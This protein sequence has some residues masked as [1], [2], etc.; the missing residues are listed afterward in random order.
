[1]K[2]ISLI[3]NSVL[4]ICVGMCVCCKSHQHAD[5][6]TKFVNQHGEED[7]SIFD[8]V[9]A[10][11]YRGKQDNISLIRGII[12]GRE[13][14][15]ESWAMTNIYYDITDSSIVK[16]VRARDEWID[17]TYASVDSTYI[18]NLTRRFVK[19]DIYEI[20]M[21]DA[22]MISIHIDQDPQSL[23]V[24]FDNDSIKRIM[25]KERKWNKVSGNWY[26]P[27]F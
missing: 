10:M 12:P 19:L 5:K 18:S 11:S 14:K 9:N 22:G 13:G 24:R 1:M 23:V 25:S 15:K 8:D 27:K 6:V 26:V 7:F 4:L 3:A 21:N 2:Y 20:R 16:L 17:S